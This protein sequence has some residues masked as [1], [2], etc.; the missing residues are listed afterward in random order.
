M[1]CGC[2]SCGGN[3]VDDICG[4]GSGHCAPFA[5]T[6]SCHCC[7][8]KPEPPPCGWRVVDG[9]RVPVYH[10]IHPL[11]PQLVSS[12]G[13]KL[14]AL[15]YCLPLNDEEI[16]GIACLLRAAEQS[17][18]TCQF[19]GDTYYQGLI[20]RTMAEV[21]FARLYSL[22]ESAMVGAIGQGKTVD[23][24]KAPTLEVTYHGQ[25]YEKLKQ[26]TSFVAVM[27]I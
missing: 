15:G 13:G 5:A 9:V 12:C 7:P 3:V 4:C 2:S 1:N 20:Y 6:A 23:Y 26:R 22:W 10:P 17:V 16:A 24:S 27:G 25:L 8:P 14:K 11:L 19:P 18:T 21:E